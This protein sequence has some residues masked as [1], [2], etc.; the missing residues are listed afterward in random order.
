MENA[1]T[2][3][4]RELTA[5]FEREICAFINTLGGKIYIGVDDNGEVYGVDNA[6]KISLAV[7]DRIK[8][9]IRPS[10]VGLYGSEV[11]E[12]DEKKYIEITIAGGLEKPYYIKKYGM[13]QSG[14]F[15]RVGAQTIPM[16]QDM[17]DNLSARRVRNTLHNVVSP[18]QNLTFTPA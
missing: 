1:T 3:Y 5:D 18:N 16:P 9:N 4:K 12:K 13:S 17:I 14:C 8:N 2:E 11:K 7:Q 15:M 10:I 6:D